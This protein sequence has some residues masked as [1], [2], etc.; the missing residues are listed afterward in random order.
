MLFRSLPSSVAN[1]ITQLRQP[2]AVMP[3]YTDKVL[4]DK[5][6]SDIYAYVQTLPKPP[7]VKTIRLLQ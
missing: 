3:P 2:K 1:F 7:D 5:D 6:I 4:A